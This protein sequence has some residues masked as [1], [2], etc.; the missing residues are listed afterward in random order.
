ME[1]CLFR[2]NVKYSFQ[3]NQ[4]LRLISKQNMSN[5]GQTVRV[6]VLIFIG[7]KPVPSDIVSCVNSLEWQ[8]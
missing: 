2:E 6:N 5:F 4:Q 8:I 1:S 7:M 3:S